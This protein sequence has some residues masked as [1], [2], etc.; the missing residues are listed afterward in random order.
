MNLYRNQNDIFTSRN[1]V[2]TYYIEIIV[3]NIHVLL[4][5]IKIYKIHCNE[6]KSDEKSEKQNYSAEVCEKLRVS[7]IE[8]L[9]MPCGSFHN[10][11]FILKNFFV[12]TQLPARTQY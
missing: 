2:T 10:F 6:R 4:K 11:L 12:G 7:H 8:K 5:G 9:I 1:K 3:W